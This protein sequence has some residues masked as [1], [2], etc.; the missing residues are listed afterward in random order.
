MTELRLSVPDEGIRGRN[1]LLRTLGPD[2]VDTLVPAF[3]D[4]EM[5]EA[6]NLPAF[7]R[8]ELIASLGDIPAMAESGRLLPLAAVDLE[9][10]EVIGAGMLHHLDRERQI[11]EICYFVLPEARRRGYATGIARLLAEHAISL[12]VERV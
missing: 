1:V 3:A 12:G 9:T 10:G 4:P 7:G 2:D 5:R 8:E 6:G 11:V